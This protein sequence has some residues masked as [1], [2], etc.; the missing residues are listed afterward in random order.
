MN[1]SSG[2]TALPLSDYDEPAPPPPSNP[3]HPRQ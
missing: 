3:A 2:R 1:E